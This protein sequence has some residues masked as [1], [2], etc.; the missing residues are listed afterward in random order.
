M[1][2]CNLLFEKKKY[3][4]Q[5]SSLIRV[6]NFSLRMSLSTSLHMSQCDRNSDLLL[7]FQP[8]TA[9]LCSHAV[10]LGLHDILSFAISGAP[11]SSEEWHTKVCSCKKSN[12][13][14][15]CSQRMQDSTPYFNLSI[16]MTPTWL[17]FVRLPSP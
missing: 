13:L 3:H 7:I 9:Q 14:D 1:G 5:C 17:C 12:V 8:I 10:V 11:A 4:R 6:D 16:C 15:K 2:E